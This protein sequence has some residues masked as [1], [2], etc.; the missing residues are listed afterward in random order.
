MLD[1]L[2]AFQ[3]VSTKA[4]EAQPLSEAWRTTPDENVRRALAQAMNRNNWFKTR[5]GGEELGRFLKETGIPKEIEQVIAAFWKR[6]VELL[7]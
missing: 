7:G 1:I 6:L 3:I 4:G 5:A 2:S